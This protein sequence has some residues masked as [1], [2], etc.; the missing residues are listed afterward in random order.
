MRRIEK[1]RKLPRQ[2]RAQMTVDAILDAAARIL[3]GDGYPAMSTNRVAELAGV[4][5]GSLYQYFPNKD[6]LVAA[7]HERHGRQIHELL[8]V[9]LRETEGSSL[10]AV[11]TALVRAALQGHLID[12]QL[13]RVLEAEFPFFDAPV[14][15]GN[16]HLDVHARLRARLA[17]HRAEIAPRDLDLANYIVRTT[18]QTMVH[19]AVI[20]PPAAFTTAQLETSIIDLVMGYLQPA[21]LRTPMRAR[22]ASA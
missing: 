11:V 19:A 6:A 7:L 5:V 13:H 12:P 15:E 9:A 4:S 10:R 3:S 14:A 1:P 22:R 2:Q 16:D 20:D 8:D 17:E 21:T 18:V